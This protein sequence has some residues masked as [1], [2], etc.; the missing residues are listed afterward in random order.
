MCGFIFHSSVAV[1]NGKVYID[2]CTVSSKSQYVP[3]NLNHFQT[4]QNIRKPSIIR[5]MIGD[6]LANE[7]DHDELYL[8]LYDK[9][10][11]CQK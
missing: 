4:L 10:M 11:T 7:R 1:M 3:I 5:K 6:I 8:L 2:F 9:S